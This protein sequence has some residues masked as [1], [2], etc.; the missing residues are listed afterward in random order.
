MSYM[1]N[2][3]SDEITS[4]VLVFLE[5]SIKVGSFVF[6]QLQ[7][8]QANNNQMEVAK[9]LE[10]YTETIPFSFKGDETDLHYFWSNSELNYNVID[11]ITDENLK[12][13][14]KKIFSEFVK[15]NFLSFENGIFTLTEK[16]KEHLFKPNF[17]K[18]V[19][20]E[21]VEFK[22]DIANKIKQEFAKSE[23]GV[24]N[25]D[26]NLVSNENEIVKESQKNL[27]AF[28][29]E[30]E[31]QVLQQQNIPHTL[32]KNEEIQLQGLKTI[33]VKEKDFNVFCSSIN[34][35]YK[36]HLQFSKNVTGEILKGNDLKNILAELGKKSLDIATLV[37]NITLKTVKTITKQ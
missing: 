35:S 37:K 13:N 15:D 3:T 9:I 20:K 30:K 19:V 2:L 11:N 27:Y 1:Q 8:A 22:Q 10:K 16:G 34:R 24:I 21:N 23:N 17:A 14:V 5:M 25:Y 12:E 6:E 7:K 29:D 28:V 4:D 31:Y 33:L 36:E 18:E 26:D 32:V